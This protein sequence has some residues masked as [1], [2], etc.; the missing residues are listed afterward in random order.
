MRI[1]SLLLMGLVAT[2]ALQAHDV[3]W[4][5]NPFGSFPS[6]PMEL[7]FG[8]D[9]CG[10][11]DY[12]EIGIVPSVGEPCTVV[13]N[14]DPPASSAIKTSFAGGISTANE[15]WIYVD[16]N[17]FM[18][19][20][21]VNTTVTGEWH[22]TGSPANAGCTATNP[23]PFSVPITVKTPI[24]WKIFLSTMPGMVQIDTG[25]VLWGLRAS[26]SLTGPWYNVGYGSNFNI[27]ADQTTQY[28][29]A[30]HR[31]GSAFGGIIM[32][33]SG[34]PQPGINLGLQY[35]GFN[36]TTFSDGSFS[37]YVLPRGTNLI[38]LTK[39]ITFVDPATGTNRTET[40]GLNIEV[41]ASNPTNLLY[42]MLQ[43]KVAML[44]FALPAC[45]CTPW[46]AIGVGTLNSAQ[47]PVFYGGGAI[48]PKSGPANCGAVQVTVTPPSG[49]TYSITSGSG[50]H[51]NSGPNPAAGTWTVT[52]T[53]CGQSKQASITVP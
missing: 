28:Y 41:P 1:A 52:T 16:V 40:V 32:D 3:I 4:W 5:E 10:F 14:L 53:V 20:R 37:S 42:A 2:G 31:F 26:S 17:P 48:P 30:T 44:L 38:A 29:K 47:T 8:L 33:G 6:N 21:D 19:V 7:E 9:D 50:K 36:M 23:N 13:V 24:L 18:G 43:F 46:C 12:G 39:P 25:G 45:N 34:A 27:M 22:A 15:V 51:Q 35:G 11:P 49:V